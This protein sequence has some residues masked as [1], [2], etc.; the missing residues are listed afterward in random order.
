MQQRCALPAGLNPRHSAGGMGR[1]GGCVSRSHVALRIRQVRGWDAEVQWKEP[2]CPYGARGAQLR[3]LQT[4]PSCIAVLAGLA[5]SLGW[6]IFMVSTNTF[7]HRLLAKRL[8][9]LGRCKGMQPS[10]SSSPMA[11]LGWLQVWGP[12]EG[13]CGGLGGS[14]SEVRSTG[15]EQGRRRGGPRP[16]LSLSSVA[17]V[18]GSQGASPSFVAGCTRC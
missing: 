15:L 10:A 8:V 9:L 3:S 16:G 1:D 12:A 6:S 17:E 5:A 13:R 4:P 11:H 2:G 7:I 18:L 14:A